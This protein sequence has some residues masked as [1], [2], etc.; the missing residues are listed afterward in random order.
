MKYFS[1]VLMV[2]VG[3]SCYEQKPKSPL[4]S[5]VSAKQS[6]SAS[7]FD[8]YFNERM[9]LYPF[10]AT[11]NDINDYNNQFPIDIS[12]NYQDSLKAFY[13]KYQNELSKLDT[14]GLSAN[15]RISYDILKW[16]LSRNIA[17]LQYHENYMPINQFWAKTLEMGQ[18]GSGEGAQPFKSVKD[19]E[20]WLERMHRFPVWVDTAIS[21]MRKGIAIGWVLPKTLAN[22]VIPQLQDMLN[23]DVEKNVFYGPLKKLN[24]IIDLREDD[25]ERI[26]A[27]YK[28]AIPSDMIESYKRLLDFFEKEYIP[29]C[30]NTSGISSL[31][32][33]GKYYNELIKNWTTTDLSADQIFEIGQKEVARI[34]KEME[35]VKDEVGFKGDLKSFFKYVN[36]N[37]ALFPYKETKDVIADFQRIYKTMQPQLEKLFDMKPKTPFEIRQTEAFREAS[38]S[39]EYNQGSPDGKRPGVFYFPIPKNDATKINCFQNEALF[40]H[41]AIPG[42]HYQVSIQQENTE[43]PKFRRF[44]E[45]GAY[46]EGYALYTESLGKELGLYKDPYQYFGKLGM[47]MHRAIRLVVDVGLH[48]KGWTRDQAIAYDLEN[49][50]DTKEAITAEIERYMAIPAQAL[51]YKTGQLKIIELRTMLQT[52]KGDK[53]DIKQFHNELLKDGCVPIRILESKMNRLK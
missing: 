46:Q 14:V 50:A 38:A 23:P 24:K 27:D 30:R 34:R 47:E 44:I 33:G 19:Y 43:M 13:L 22:K 26:R 53:F 18:Y 6:A 35:F 5:S 37:K 8:N 29:N 36:E 3:V 17:T 28:K 21:N 39:A 45:F 15:D 16:E 4:T 1:L 48:T 41:E 25:K 9:R 7:L 52:A 10:E 32:N 20:N 31:P 2:L 51:S 40:L 49:E 42:H 11:Q 12:D